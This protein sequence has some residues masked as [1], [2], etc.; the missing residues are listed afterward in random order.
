MGL[1]PGQRR[2]RLIY[3]GSGYR[4]KMAM[5]GPSTPLRIAMILNGIF[6]GIATAW[7]LY[8]DISS[9]QIT[10]LPKSR[11]AAERAA[12]VRDKALQAARSGC[13]RGDLWAELA[14]TYASLEWADVSRIQRGDLAGAKNSATRAI[15][16][17]PGNSAVWLLLADLASRFSWETPNPV[18]SLKMS[19]YTGP[20]E[21]D[22]APLRLMLSARLDHAA[23]AEL[24]R[25]F[26]QQLESILTSEPALRP[27]VVAAYKGGTPEARR[28]VEDTATRLDPPFA[29]T[30]VGAGRA[31]PP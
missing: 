19:Y 18:E 26:R 1:D 21:Q 31:T 9:A 15:R 20:H 30:L 16:L 14:F 29:Q 10:A 7:L 22:L 11:E 5:V 13:V 24:D 25:L 27:A 28:L 3:D 8:S 2:I 23:D 17:M 4:G 6:L 12:S